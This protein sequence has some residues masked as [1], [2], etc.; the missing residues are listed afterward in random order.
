MVFR[1]TRVS[2]RLDGRQDLRVRAVAMD[3]SPIPSSIPSVS[4]SSTK[5]TKITATIGPASNTLDML[6]S[7]AASGM[8]VCRLNMSHGTHES[9]MEVVEMV[10]AYNA[11]A[12]AA[13][14]P[15]LAILLDTKGPEVRSGDVPMPIRLSPGDT[16]VFTI[17]EGRVQF[18][19]GEKHRVS[20]NY[21]GFLEDVS[22]GDRVLVDGGILSMDVVEVDAVGGDVVCKVVDGGEMGSRRH[23][24]VRGKSA[25]LPAITDKDWKDIAWGVY[26]AGVDYFA[27]SFVRDAAVIH[28]LRS[29][30]EE[31]VGQRDGATRI[32]IL[33]KIESAE[34]TKHLDEILDAVDGAMVARGDLGAELPVEEVPFWQA[35]IV[36]GCRRR[37]KPCIVATNMLESMITHPLATRAEVTDISVAVRE[38]ADAVMLSGETAYGGYPVKSVQMMRDVC[39]ETE[40]G[41]DGCV[42]DVTGTPMGTPMGTAMGT[43]AA[44]GEITMS[45]ERTLAEVIAFHA[46]QMSD[47][48]G[49]PLIVF[50]RRGSLPKLLSRMRPKAMVYCFTDNE[51][52]QRRLAL[53]HGV[54]AFELR[55]EGSDSE[56][57]FADASR[58]LLD[59]GLVEA[60]DPVVVVRG[61][62]EPIWKPKSPYA[63]QIRM[64][65]KRE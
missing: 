12:R 38:G 43:M 17:H 44:A 26:D 7:L 8:N 33:A 64:V 28:E 10:R 52:V 16:F 49:C 23:I 53:Y 41:L 34:S 36:E 47:T 57:A 21:D 46:A 30:L 62:K 6:T 35:A 27:L 25:N 32:G 48:L 59:K 45:E 19:D 29:Y 20:I 61:G 15:T 22:V 42:G 55:L 9:H 24:N 11:R 1:G 39:R 60:G 40:A 14:E 18:G 54:Q 51:V 65:E 3:G 37:G 13:G 5:K 58:L 31:E 2:P 56:Q 50:S 63:C 4:A